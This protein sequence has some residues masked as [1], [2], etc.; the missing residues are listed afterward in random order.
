M[1]VSRS[2]IPL[3]SRVAEHLYWSARYL[4]RASASARVL[5][6]Y[7]D[8][9]VDL[10]VSAV[11]SW[12]PL[13]AIPGSRE[14]FD[15]VYEQP[16]E[17][18]V[19]TF[20]VAD[21]QNP[22]A[23][24]TSIV[25]ARANLRTVR[26][27]VPE[28]M[29]RVLND[30]ALFV[31][32][33]RSDGVRRRSRPRFFE[34][35]IADCERLEGVRVA[36]MLRD[37][38]YEF[39]RLGQAIE[40][41]DMTTRVLAV[42]A[43]YLMEESEALGSHH[44]VQWM[45]VLRSLAAYQAF[46]RSTREPI[47][48][49]AV[50]SF[51]LHHR[52][53]QRSVA[54]C[55]HRVTQAVS[56]LPP[57]PQIIEEAARVEAE[58]AAI[59][60]RPLDGKSLDEA[61]DAVQ[62]GLGSVHSR[63]GAAYF[64]P[65][66]ELQPR[67]RMTAI[68]GVIGR[69]DGPAHARPLA[70]ML[71]LG[72]AT[73]HE[74]QQDAA[75]LLHAQ[76][77][78]H[79]IHEEGAVASRPWKLDPI[80]IVIDADTW[81]HIAGGVA[82]RMELLEAVLDDL[83]GDR[84]LLADGV[85]PVEAV[86]GLPAYRLPLVGARPPSGPRLVVHGVDLVRTATG[87]WQVLRD[88]TDAPTGLGYALLNRS[89]LARLVAEPFRA[90]GVARLTPFEATMRAALAAL[91]PPGRE[92]GRVVVLTG[93]VEHDSFVEHALL[94]SMLGYHLAEADDLAVRDGRVW[95]RSIEGLEPVDA[96]FR[97]LEDGAC[98]PLELFSADGI[99]G[100]A[101]AVRA[102]QTGMANFLGSAVAGS[103]V[104]QPFLDDCAAL[105]LGAPLRLTG[106]ASMWCGDPRSRAEVDADLG[107][108][109]LYDTA[110]RDVLGGRPVAVF[111]D[112]LDDDGQQTWRALLRDVPE[113]IVSQELVEF[114]STPVLGPSGIEQGE[115]VLRVVAVH[116]P[117]GIDVLPGGVGRVVDGSMPVLAQ[118]RG[119]GGGVVKDVW[120][121]GGGPR[122]RNALR[123]PPDR[124]DLRDSLPRRAAEAL[125]WA[126]RFLE[127]A[128]ATARLLKV[129][130]ERSGE[131]P[132]LIVAEE[133]AWV[134]VVAAGLVAATGRPPAIADAPPGA[135]IGRE[136]GG[137]AA[138]ARIAVVGAIDGVDGL[139]GSLRGLARN[140][141]SA[142]QYL[143]RSTSDILMDLGVVIDELEATQATWTTRLESTVDR[144]I[145]DLAAI[146]GLIGESTVRG[147]GWRFLD[148]G[149]R[150]ER[151]LVM[152]G[153][154]E[155]ML[156]V[157]VVASLDRIV[158]DT[159]LAAHESL[160]AYRRRHRTDPELESVLD[161]L[162]A[163]DTNPRSLQFQ[164]D[165]LRTHVWALPARPSRER[166]ASLVEETALAVAAVSW[167]DPADT[168]GRRMGVDRL[169]LEVR[170]PLLTFVEELT[171]SW[172]TDLA[173]HRIGTSE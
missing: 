119:A 65:V 10:P 103:L 57:A 112:H 161:L 172:F 83:Y 88:A 168:A 15:A 47:S 1:T 169:V 151:I 86:A 110:P 85:I 62:R 18:S 20:L 50:V 90:G 48:G 118:P 16:D 19:M 120:V 129:I 157:P 66:P 70:D 109:V 94:A 152:V 162:A 134:S 92:H 2:A 13:L 38:A 8:T 82:Q 165:R 173:V 44:E 143:S 43:A 21:D 136:I 11:S 133:G 167:L 79:V 98:D 156:S 77:A 131:D 61:M 39:M 14:H 117:S 23:V 89:V 42:R 99:P 36:T 126:G 140:A 80:P 128:D 141:A 122:V 127:R 93:G 71:D 144:V 81:A 155:S 101:S 96:I 34:R 64:L 147:P 108:F 27:V 107:R 95:L 60:D 58:L 52:S 125:Y 3:L 113:R 68:S 25:Q 9:L 35:V 46:Q 72:S 138:A 32:S 170:G 74:L 26:E 12:E 54:A 55:L 102:G 115:V 4:E 97:R 154:F 30:L 40:R 53:F 49:E 87:E 166:L 63:V 149:R 41:A 76:A 160:V 33:D 158:L 105:L 7:S 106:M 69:A 139:T 123:V 51:V 28:T 150:V 116:G 22:G 67:Q 148:I 73:L 17:T 6:A 45:G 142:R 29:W 37:D 31:T 145:V 5:R 132:G 171:T 75:R 111:G 56:T 146:S 104:L 153:S 59:R 84:R 130:V 121:M 163:D 24:V 100:L 159:V 164:I 137:A 124:I 114:A 91:V 78:T 135:P